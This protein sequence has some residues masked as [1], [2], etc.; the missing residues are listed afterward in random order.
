MPIPHCMETTGILGRTIAFLLH[1]SKFGSLFRRYFLF[2]RGLRV[3]ACPLLQRDQCSASSGWAFSKALVSQF[4]HFQTIFQDRQLLTGQLCSTIVQAI[5]SRQFPTVVKQ[6]ARPF[7]FK[8]AQTC[9]EC[10]LLFRVGFAA[11]NDSNA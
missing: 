10:L 3:N 9:P 2:Q 1:P 11:S 4:H 8:F 5:L 6:T 7:H